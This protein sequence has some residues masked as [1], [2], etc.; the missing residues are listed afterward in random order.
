MTTQA[1]HSPA[2]QAALAAIAWEFRHS[3]A[4]AMAR[5]WI[6]KS[7]GHPE[8]RARFAHQI[9]FFVRHGVTLNQA[10]L[11]A[12]IDCRVPHPGERVALPRMARNEL[13][14]ILRWMRA[15]KMHAAF[16]ETV[17]AMR[18]GARH[19]NETLIAAE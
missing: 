15:R 11:Y 10:C 5:Q 13:R 14:L 7:F 17:A 9:D 4:N 6:R 3:P 19:Q 12:A 16:A 2:L 1:Q 18:M 8:T